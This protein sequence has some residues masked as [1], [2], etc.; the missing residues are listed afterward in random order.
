MN[1]VVISFG[2]FLS[3]AD[4]FA[5]RLD[6]LNVPEDVAAE[7]PVILRWTRTATARY[8]CLSRCAIR[9]VVAVCS[10]TY[11]LKDLLD[12]LQTVKDQLEMMGYPYP[13]QR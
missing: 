11:R 13:R 2:E 3:F 1:R 7:I 9:E 5:D 8:L 10:D 12:G 6:A 4:E